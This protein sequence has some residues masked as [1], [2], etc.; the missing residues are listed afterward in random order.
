MFDD[1]VIECSPLKENSGAA[2]K[3]ITIK[4]TR[5]EAL[6]LCADIALQMKSLPLLKPKSK[7]GPV[8]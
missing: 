4:L 2:E 3:L 8:P 6:Q 1:I 5:D 7:S